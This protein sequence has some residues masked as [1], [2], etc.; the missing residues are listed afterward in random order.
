VPVHFDRER[1]W[2]DA[3]AASE[4]RD[5]DDEA[6]NRALRWREIERHLA[7]IRT[8]LDVGGGTGAFSIPL[9]RRGYEVTH[10]DHSPVMLALA[11]EKAAGTPSIRLVEG[12]STDLRMFADRS[13]DLVLNTDGAISF[14]GELAERAL[15][16]S[17]RVARRKLVATVT[18]L[19]W[20]VPVLLSGSLLTAGNILPAAI[21]MLN[22]R[23]WRQDEYPDNELLTRGTTQGYFGPL[24]AFT[25]VE[26]RRLVE[27]NGLSTL[28]VG[29]LGSLAGLCD[30][31]VVRAAVS[32]PVQYER[33]LDMCE[34]FDREVMPDGPGTRVRA[35]LIA[36]AARDR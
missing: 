32:D 18:S 21:S 25:S 2:W 33:F 10:L 22:R 34:Q 1:L 20:L 7:G 14:C 9:A 13:F 23:R 35:G 26:L 4:E 8:I 36:V 12:S 29:G 27:A 3:K 31:E 28:R 15:A 11:R 19:G 30:R 5:S 6:V 24:R 16:E 17:C